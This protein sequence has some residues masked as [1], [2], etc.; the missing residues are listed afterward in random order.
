MLNN[1]SSKPLYEQIEEDIKNKIL[2]NELVKGDRVGSHSELTN[3]YGVSII[4]VKKALNNLISKG[5]LYTRVGKGTYV[6]EPNIK[7]GKQF[8]GHK[9]IGLVLKDINHPFFSMIVHSIEER[10]YELD[11]T[12][13]LSSSSNKIE[14]EEHQINHFREMGVDGLIIASLSLQYRAT[15]YIQKLHDENFPY[16]MISYMHDPQYWFIGS[17][18]EK[19]AFLATEHLIKTGYKKIGYVYLGRDNL[20]TEVRKNGY[21]RALMEYNFPYNTKNIFSYADEKY[22]M[23]ENRIKLGYKFGKEFAKMNDRPEA[24]LFYGDTTALGFVKAMISC[25]IKVPN[26]VAVIGYDDIALA[27]LAAVPLTTIRQPT[28]KIG[29]QAVDVIH[30][31]INKEEIMNRIIYEPE[32]VVRESCGGKKKDSEFMGTTGLVSDSI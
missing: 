7:S 21:A 12:L 3:Q 20:L 23:G 24:L 10:A 17:D 4:T 13:L 14:K 27:S 31:R 15:P 11:Y 19:G 6:A 8:S 1:N 9:T 5:F 32:L 28:Q 30:K 2:T 22:D 29:A 16:I 25:G 18:N 26:E